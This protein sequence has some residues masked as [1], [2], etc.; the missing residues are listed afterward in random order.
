MTGLDEPGYVGH[1][2]VALDIAAFID[3]ER[4]LDRIDALAEHIHSSPTRKGV[5]RVLVPGELEANTTIARRRDGVPYP[6]SVYRA[7]LDLAD[8]AGLDVTEP[9]TG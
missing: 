6:R 3:V 5:E 2:F 1:F 4:F 7:L 9:E 8:K